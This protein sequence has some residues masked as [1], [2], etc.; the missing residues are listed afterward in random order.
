MT[1]T[2][3]GDTGLWVRKPVPR[4]ETQRTASG[5][6]L[7]VMVNFRCRPDRAKRRPQRWWKH[8]VGVHQW[9]CPWK[10]LALTQYM[11]SRS[12]LLVWLDITQSTEGWNGTRNWG[13]WV[14]FL[15]LSWDVPPLGSGSLALL[16]FT[17]SAPQAFRP[18]WSAP[19]PSWLYRCR[20]QIV[21][22]SQPS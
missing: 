8:Y 1:R 7:G 9:A 21:A 20:Q 12:P 11:E 22:L 18:D 15:C 6:E 17:L 16:E 4:Q 5:P 13:R 2:Q 10:R 14:Y 3:S 19:L